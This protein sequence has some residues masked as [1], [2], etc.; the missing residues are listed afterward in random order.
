MQFSLK[1]WQ[2]LQIDTEKALSSD[3]FLDIS[4]DS[5]LTFVGMGKMNILEET[6]VAALVKW[7]KSGAERSGEDPNN[8]VTLRA[9]LLPSLKLIKFGLMN[10]LNFARLCQRELGDILT[11]DEKLSIF[12]TLCYWDKDLLPAEFCHCIKTSERRSELHQGVS[13]NFTDTDLKRMV[14]KEAQEE[15]SIIFQINKK[16]S[17]TRVSLRCCDSSCVELKDS[18][19]KVLIE[20][21]YLRDSDI[22]LA[23]HSDYVIKITYDVFLREEFAEA[24]EG[25]ECSIFRLEENSSNSSGWLTLTVKSSQSFINVHHIGLSF[26]NVF[27]YP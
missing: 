19:G 21:G 12:E 22:V 4:P 17:L 1:F 3:H 8:G 15:A 14:A 23:A 10:E 7:A 24:E 20:S 26:K 11:V 2:V 16:A 6:L 9:S 25:K 13:F 18:D 5:I 27:I